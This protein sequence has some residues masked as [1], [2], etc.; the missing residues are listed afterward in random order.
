MPKITI[1]TTT[2]CPYC[3][4]AKALFKNKKVKFG[5]INVE[6]DEEKRKWLRET[7]G[8]KTVPQIF[9]DDKPI[10]GYQELVGLEQKGELDKIL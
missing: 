8:Q 2:Y 4:A 5:E 6:G 1:Y 3:R 7:T 9:I 10:G